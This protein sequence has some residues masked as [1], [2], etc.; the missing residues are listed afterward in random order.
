MLFPWL[1]HHKLPLLLSV[2]LLLFSLLSSFALP[3]WLLVALMM[4]IWGGASVFHKRYADSANDTVKQNSLSQ[5]E[6]SEFNQLVDQFNDEIKLE[7]AKVKAELN[8]VSDLTSEAIHTLNQNFNTL[9]NN[10]QQQHQGIVKLIENISH[11]AK[12][13]DEDKGVSVKDFAE[14]TGKTLDFFVQLLVDLSSNSIRIVHKID[15]MVDHMNDIFK[16]LED[17]SAIA[18]QTNLLALNAAIEAARAG[19]AGRGFAVV[20]DEVRKLSQNSEE[21]N[22]KI[23]E[24][25]EATQKTVEEARE[26]VGDMASKDMNVALTAKARV[27]NVLESVAELNITIEHK[28]NDISKIT[29]EIDANVGHAVRS[30]QFEDLVSQTLTTIDKHLSYLDEHVTDLEEATIMINNQESNENKIQAIKVL[31]NKL[32]EKRTMKM[33]KPVSQETMTEGDIELF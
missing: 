30:L 11:G 18:Q 19:E 17:V 6:Q 9:H 7:S 32:D 16:L 26:I 27:K 23:R 33:H 31:L 5:Q 2:G 22:M 28:V 12:D 10:T 20:A 8:R 4:L 29:D 15:D 21:F 24:Q 13:K 1:K 14:E 3:D 25:V